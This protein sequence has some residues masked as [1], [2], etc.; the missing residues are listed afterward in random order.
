MTVT[1][2]PSHAAA[3]S[4]GDREAKRRFVVRAVFFI[5]LLSLIEGPLRKWFLPGLAG[6]LTLLRD[7]FVIALYAYCLVNGMMRTR[8]IAGVW[9]MFA[10]FTSAIGLFQFLAAGLPAWGWMLGVRTYW[11]Y[12]PLAFVVAKT[13]RREDIHLF[14]KL[15][16]WISIP[17]AFLVAAQYNAPPNAFINLGVGADEGGAVALGDGILRPFGLFTYTAPNVQLPLMM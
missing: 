17:Y 12:L 7:P 11:L 3:A 5:F 10:F 4:A 15:C 6:P 2:A 8:G 14:L 13:F 9:L 16:L 1:A